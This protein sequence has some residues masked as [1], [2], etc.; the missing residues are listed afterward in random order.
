MIYGRIY[1]ITNLINEKIYI[2]LTT[3]TLDDRFC[4]HK[5]ASRCDKPRYAIHKAI[6]KYGEHNFTIELLEE[7]STKLLLDRAEIKWIDRLNSRGKLG[8][9]LT[10]GGAS[11]FS[12]SQETRKLISEKVRGKIK[13]LEAIE[14]FKKS[15]AN[16][17]RFHRR[18]VPVTQYDKLGNKIAEHISIHHASIKITGDRRAAQ[19]IWSCCNGKKSSVCGFVFRYKDSEFTR[20]YRVVQQYLDSQLIATF[21]SLKEAKLM[22]GINHISACCRGVRKS[23]GGYTWKYHELIF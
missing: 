2:G 18:Y 15:A 10:S 20:A 12:H 13:S 9:N 6:K 11:G 22:T 14:K 23:A 19:H 16:S 8:Y 4:G 5:K 3:K 7:C 21:A 1:K 17:E